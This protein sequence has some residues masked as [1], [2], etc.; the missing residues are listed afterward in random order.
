MALAPKYR[1]SLTVESN[2]NLSSSA[3]ANYMIACDHTGR[4]FEILNDLGT[5][6]LHDFL[7]EICYDRSDFSA[8]SYYYD[9]RAKQ[10]QK[11]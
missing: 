7:D 11:G 9:M 10:R 2:K 6:N 4:T 5:A 3:V 8:G 1:N